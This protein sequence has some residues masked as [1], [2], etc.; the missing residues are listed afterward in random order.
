[1]AIKDDVAIFKARYLEE[2]FGSKALLDYFISRY[3]A[4]EVIEF[5]DDFAGA[6]DCG[7]TLDWAVFDEF[8]WAIE[9]GLLEAPFNLE[10]D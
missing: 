5:M 10:E 4:D 9:D 3:H 8:D 1:M 2:Q 6:N 7:Y